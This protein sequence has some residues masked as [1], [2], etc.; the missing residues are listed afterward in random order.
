MPKLP[1]S[2]YNYINAE[3]ISA[4]SIHLTHVKTWKRVYKWL[5]RPDIQHNVIIRPDHC[6]SAT[7]WR[8]IMP[9]VLN[10]LRL[11]YKKRN[12]TGTIKQKV[13]DIVHS[14]IPEQINVKS[15]N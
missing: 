7:T 1:G 9:W 6:V 15:S 14:V 13:F 4:L 11:K 10:S 2:D 3:M 8:D 5:V 12:M